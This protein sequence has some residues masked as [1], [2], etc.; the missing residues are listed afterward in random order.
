MESVNNTELAVIERG[1]DLLG[2]VLEEGNGDPVATTAAVAKWFLALEEQR[3][4]HCR[5]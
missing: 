4:N 2:L 3:E 5:H 1:A